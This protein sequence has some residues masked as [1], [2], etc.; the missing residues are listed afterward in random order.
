MPMGTYSALPHALIS[1]S[2]HTFRRSLS[3]PLAGRLGTP[4]DMAGMAL[5]LASPAS[6][7]VTGVHILLDGGATLV[8]GKIGPSVKL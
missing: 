4:G 6:A 1:A 3:P 2:I 8:A 5:F 7:H